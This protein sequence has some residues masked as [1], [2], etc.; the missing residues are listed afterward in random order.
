MSSSNVK[1]NY[2]LRTTWS[3]ITEKHTPTK[4]ESTEWMWRKFPFL[5]SVNTKFSWKWMHVSMSFVIIPLGIFYEVAS[6]YL[7]F[8]QSRTKTWRAAHKFF[9]RSTETSK[10]FVWKNSSNVSM[11][12]YLWYDVISIPTPWAAEARE[13]L[14]VDYCSRYYP[15]KIIWLHVSGKKEYQS[16]SVVLLFLLSIEL[17]CW[18]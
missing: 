12:Q 2:R 15:M 14:Y 16:S 9:L 11:F 3:S 5:I 8:E 13:I 10:R 4:A 7:N 1:W 18:L 17:P 6:A